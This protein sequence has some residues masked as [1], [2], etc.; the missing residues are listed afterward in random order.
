M[1]TVAAAVVYGFTIA[2]AATRA[3]ALLLQRN[4][5][6]STEKYGHE[7]DNNNSKI[8]ATC[9]NLCSAPF[10]CGNVASLHATPLHLVKVR[11]E[12]IHV[13]RR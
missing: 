3:C 5:V 6:L 1:L 7:D 8:T 9:K 11:P 2:A 12:C 4:I 13:P 10:P